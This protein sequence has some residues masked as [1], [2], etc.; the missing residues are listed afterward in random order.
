MNSEQQRENL[1]RTGRTKLL[2]LAWRNIPRLSLFGV[3]LLIIL[4][5]A[6]IQ[7]KKERLLQEK[8]AA[9]AEARQPVNT[10]LLELKPA[11]IKD[12]INLPGIIE[13][14]VKL[15]LMAKVNGSIDEVLVREGD[16]IAQ[17]QVLARIEADDY[18]IALDSAR[19]AYTLARAEFERGKLMLANKTIPQ[20][21][22][23]RF[24]SRMSTAK[25]AMEDAELRLS[26]CT[27]TAPM[28]GV[29]RRLDAK[30]GLFLNIGD[31][32]AEILQIDRV[33]AVVGIPESDVAAV[34][35]LAEVDLTIQA[36]ASRRFTGRTYFLSPSPE[37]FARLYRL[38]LEL[39]N[40]DGDI[41]PGMFFRAHV[42]KQVVDDAISVPLYSIITRG[43]EQFVF[44][45]RDGM[46]HKQ[47][48]QLG[49]IEG[50][51][52]QITEGLAPGDQVVIEGHREVEEGQQINVIQVLS[53][54]GSLTL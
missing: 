14:W 11:P 20:A 12:A 10:V 48:V 35:T 6:V 33:K 49:I 40:P 42:V 53:D 47:P 28:N 1:A 38:E 46:V 32:V 52:V 18:R 17:G 3:F 21:E 44:V 51:Q 13:P 36:L 41:L 34:R 30:I 37:S 31:P 22:L 23:E 15:E 27:I 39:A 24:E 45:A 25:A 16:R 50:W 7:G 26:R 5:G 4:L 19:A 8:L 29:I 2:F 43:K 54:P 9:R